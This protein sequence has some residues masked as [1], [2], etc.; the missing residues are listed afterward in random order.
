[1][2]F[3]LILNFYKYRNQEQNM[4]CNCINL[5]T[6]ALDWY[7]A[8]N[9]LTSTTYSLKE[10][11][12]YRKYRKLSN[13]FGNQTTSPKV[14]IK[15]GKK[16]VLI[17]LKTY[18]RSLFWQWQLNLF[19]TLWTKL[20]TIIKIRPLI[21]QVKH[22]LWILNFLWARSTFFVLW[23]IYLK[24]TLT[25]MSLNFDNWPHSSQWMLWLVLKDFLLT[26]YIGPCTTTWK[27][28]SRELLYLRNYA[29]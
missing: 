16:Q 1:M 17:R 15:N 7:A 26:A 12:T 14:Q 29:K 11:N 27:K 23:H 13:K 18:Y 20:P 10:K 2:G 3:W 19:S 9:S 4:F 6:F 5:L 22:N 21:E 25:N 28:W 8:Y 24:F